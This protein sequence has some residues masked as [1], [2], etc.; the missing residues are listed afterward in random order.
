M[1]NTFVP[2]SNFRLIAAVLDY[3]RLGKQRVEAR[4]ILQALTG[5]KNGWSHHTAVRMWIGYEEALKFYINCMIDEW[6]AR[7]YKNSMEK[8]NVE[9][10]HVI[11]PW[12]I[13]W[14]PVQYS[15]RASLY[16]KK[17]EYYKNYSFDDIPPIYHKCGYIW[18]SKLNEQQFIQAQ[19]DIKENTIQSNI[20]NISS[21]IMKAK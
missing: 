3:K 4:Q 17:P 6:I 10:E 2:F 20:L 1:V 9:E 19:H 5:E 16:R 7:G 21:P 18:P 8:Y 13:R 12:W 11:F 14:R 15:H